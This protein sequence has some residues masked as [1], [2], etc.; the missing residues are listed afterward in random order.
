MTAKSNN[1]IDGPNLLVYHMTTKHT[2]K[3]INGFFKYP[4]NKI[5]DSGRQE[6]Q[7]CCTKGKAN[8]NKDSSRLTKVVRCT[9]TSDRSRTIF[10]FL[11]SWG[12]RQPQYGQYGRGCGIKKHYLRYCP[13]RTRIRMQ[14]QTPKDRYRLC[15]SQAFLSGSPKNIGT[16]LCS[17]NPTMITTCRAQ[18]RE[19]RRGQAWFGSEL[20]STWLYYELKNKTW[21]VSQH[22]KFHLE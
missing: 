14:E 7:Y 8:K 22:I 1:V 9:W 4:T 3:L 6:E 12:M 21:L 16:S 18:T 20:G 13:Y 19:P 10:F 17:S 5:T 11:R 2:C 15:L